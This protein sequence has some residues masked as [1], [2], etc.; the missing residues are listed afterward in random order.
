MINT[1]ARGVNGVPSNYTPSSQPI[2]P[3][4][5]AGT[6]VDPNFNDTNNVIVRLANGTNQLVAYDTGLHPWRNQAV[7][8]L[9]INSTNASLYKSVAVTER[10]NLRVS[11]DAFNVFNQPGMAL[12][13]STTGI[14]SLQTSAQGARFLQY[15]ARLTW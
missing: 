1:G 4:P 15:G 2:N 14:L 13:N 5:P 10:V 12:P 6:T 3:A 11:V 7:H 8:G 9:W